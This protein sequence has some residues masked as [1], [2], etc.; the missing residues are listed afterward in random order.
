MRGVQAR[1]GMSRP[2]IALRASP[3]SLLLLRVLPVLLILLL[4]EGAGRLSRV[5]RAVIVELL[6]A[7]RKSLTMDSSAMEAREE[8]QPL[9]RDNWAV[10]GGDRVASANG[11]QRLR[12]CED[13][14][15]GGDGRANKQPWLVALSRGI[16]N[17]S[18]NGY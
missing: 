4:V 11:E 13:D 8:S 15:G 17:L 3:C 5:T 18:Q 14:E 12:H 9:P 6:A 1:N 10:D 2:A 16:A 7:P